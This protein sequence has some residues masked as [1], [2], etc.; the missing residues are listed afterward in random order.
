MTFFS[1]FIA[2]L[3]FAAISFFISS[4][5][6]GLIVTGLDFPRQ[7]G[8][9]L[10]LIVAA[11]IAIICLIASSGRKAWGH[12]SLIVG[13]LFVIAPFAAKRLH[14][15]IAAKMQTAVDELLSQ[16]PTGDANTTFRITS[17]EVVSV[18]S[19]PGTAFFV[20]GSI[21]ILFG[22]A[23]LISKRHTQP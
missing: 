6:T 18:V 20:L 11:V 8:L 9:I 1:K 7:H 21:F 5:I 3:L 13:L 10:G 17:A 19:G 12:G 16:A 15:P 2:A 4:P 23:L 14:N 22:L